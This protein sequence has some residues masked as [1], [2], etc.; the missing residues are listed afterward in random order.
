MTVVL[1]EGD[2]KPPVITTSKATSI[3][4]YD[5]EGVLVRAIAVIPG[6]DVTLTT[7]KGDEDFTS[8]IT[9][10]RIPQKL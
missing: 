8:N 1:R 6:S 10:L 3:C 9:E 2:E 5:S 4:F 7:T